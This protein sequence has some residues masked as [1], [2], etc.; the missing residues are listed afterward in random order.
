MAKIHLQNP[1][2]DGKAL[3]RGT[4]IFA[5]TLDNDALTIAK[6]AKS[7]DP[8]ASS[9]LL[10]VKIHTDTIRDL[11]SHQLFKT[12][13]EESFRRG[14]ELEITQVQKNPS[15]GYGWLVTTSPEQVVKLGRNK[16]PVLGELLSPSIPSDDHSQ[17]KTSSNAIV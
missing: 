10:T 15:E 6:V 14:H 4:R 2:E 7:Y 5:I 16:V 9:N 8:L 12:I 1:E 11:E 3:L 13:V 17:G